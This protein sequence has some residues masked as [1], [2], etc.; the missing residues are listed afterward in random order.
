MSIL[1]ITLQ[2]DSESDASQSTAGGKK[3][4]TAIRVMRPTISSQNKIIMNKSNLLRRRST[5]SSQST[6]KTVF[7]DYTKTLFFILK[8]IFSCSKYYWT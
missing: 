1:N 7:Y 8:L 3:N 5:T 4:T 6:S 2:S